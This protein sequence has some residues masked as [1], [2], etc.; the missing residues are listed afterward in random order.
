[1]AWEWRFEK[2][3]GS[4][5]QPAE[6]P[7]DFGTQGDAESWIGEIWPELLDGGIDQVTLL[8]DGT[9]VYGPMSLHSAVDD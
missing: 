8:E 4:T 9:R 5:T 3:D 2:A 6:D 1:M 7:G